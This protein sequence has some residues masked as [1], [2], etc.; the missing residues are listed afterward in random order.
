MAK[1]KAE[2]CKTIADLRGLLIEISGSLL[3]INSKIDNLT[4]N[5]NKLEK[6]SDEAEQ[7]IS[8]AEDKLKIIGD[9]YDAL[10]RRIKLLEE[11]NVE[12]KLDN[13]VTKKQL[14]DT[15]QRLRMRTIRF[16]NVKEKITDGVKSG[17]MLFE[18]FIRPAL[19]ESMDESEIPGMFSVLEYAHHLPAMPGADVERAGETYVAKFSSRF[20]KVKYTFLHSRHVCLLSSILVF[21]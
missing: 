10:I 11:D 17:R 5:V 13:L 20:F 14:N 1:V 4:G 7:R 3:S 19:A 21:F 15:Q 2:D 16:Y 9:N 8:D 18:K 6:R 12:I